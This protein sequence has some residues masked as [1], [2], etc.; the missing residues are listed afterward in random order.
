MGGMS[1]NCMKC[2]REIEEDH[3]FCSYCLL[4]MEQHPV[5]PGTVIL[6]PSQDKPAGKKAVKKKKPTPT[7]EEQVENLKKKLLIHRIGAAVLAVAVCGLIYL[8]GRVISELD[9]QRLLGQNYSSATDA[10]E[11][12]PSWFSVFD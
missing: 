6:L 7:P 9:I 12:E 2:G 1:M 10:E 4:D 5:K 8:S 11:T 3:A